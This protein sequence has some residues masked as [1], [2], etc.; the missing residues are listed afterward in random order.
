MCKELQ[1]FAAPVNRQL[2][3][4]L[5]DFA[6]KKAHNKEVTIMSLSLNHSKLTAY[7]QTYLKNGS[8]RATD[9]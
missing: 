8:S 4:S 9:A 7:S 6:G 5:R 1:K 2:R 3:H